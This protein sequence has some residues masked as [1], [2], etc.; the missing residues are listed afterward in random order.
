LLL[1]TLNNTQTH[2]HTHPVGLP[3][4][5]NEPVAEASTSATHKIQRHKHP[6]PQQD[7]NPQFKQLSGCRLMPYTARP[8]G[9]EVFYFKADIF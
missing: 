5:K 9:S 4:M 6:C 8:P 2:T 3:W 1:I 7:L